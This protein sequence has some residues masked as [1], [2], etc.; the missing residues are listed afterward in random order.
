MVDHS[1]ENDRKDGVAGFI[2]SETNRGATREVIKWIV[3]QVKDKENVVGIELLNEATEDAG[4]LG[5]WCESSN[6]GVG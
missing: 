5:N 6:V 3:E 2:S 4:A 1:G